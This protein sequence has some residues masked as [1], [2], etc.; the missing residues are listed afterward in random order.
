MMVS[1]TATLVAHSWGWDELLFF[2]IPIVLALVGIRWVE[3][4]AASRYA[5]SH[6]ENAAEDGT[7]LVEDANQDAAPA[8][9]GSN[10]PVR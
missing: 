6:G 10:P 2:G 9:E 8:D 5:E 4:R 7:E 3:R 1:F